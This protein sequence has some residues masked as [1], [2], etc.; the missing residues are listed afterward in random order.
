MSGKVL[1]LPEITL[2]SPLHCGRLESLDRHRGVGKLKRKLAYY[3]ASMTRW[4]DWVYKQYDAH[5]LVNKVLNEL[6]NFQLGNFF[7][8]FI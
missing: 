5:E 4:P 6:K 8:I 2:P 3:D 1:I 7:S